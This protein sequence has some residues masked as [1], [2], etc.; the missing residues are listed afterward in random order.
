MY[1]HHYIV[2]WIRHCLQ[3]GVSLINI[4]VNYV[5]LCTAAEA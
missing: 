4:V 1:P 3:F 5:H 2:I